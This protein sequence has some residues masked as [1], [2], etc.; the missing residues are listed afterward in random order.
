MNGKVISNLVV[1]AL[2]GV[3]IFAVCNT[4]HQARAEERETA[5]Y[6]ANGSYA[7]SVHNYGKT[8]TFTD[9]NGHFSGSAIN[10]GNGTSSFYGPRGNFTGSA[11]SRGRGR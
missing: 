4:I 8:Q 2:M 7:G 3:I 5:V 9:R 1:M 6:D 10:N 11:S